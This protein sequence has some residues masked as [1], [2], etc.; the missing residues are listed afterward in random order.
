[1]QENIYA[2]VATWLAFGLDIEKNIFFKQSDVTEVMEL[3]WIISCFTPYP[4]LANAHSFKD[5]QDNLADINA[6]LF[7]YPVLM[8]ADIIMYDVDFVPVGKDQKQHVEITRDIANKINSFFNSEL[9]VLPEAII[10]ENLMT[11]PGIDGRKM[12]KSYGNTIN[13]FLND[14]DL[15]KNINQ[16]VTDSTPVEEAKNP[17]NCNVFKI[18]S[19]LASKNESIELANKYKAGNF[20]YGHAKTA[21]YELI[22]DKYQQER[23]EYHI[24]NNDKAYLEQVLKAGADRARNIASKK[25]K[26]LR[27]IL[28]YNLS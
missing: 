19:L 3:T 25:L 21:L 12:S 18:Y 13:I 20:G 15:K 17:D 23:K 6:G 24:L 2:V 11:I 22:L 26:K 1:L 14:K 27:D 16:I 4:M 7:T 10:D 8:A 28:G 5:K 9:F